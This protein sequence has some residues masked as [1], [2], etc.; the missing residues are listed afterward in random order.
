MPFKVADAPQWKLATQ[1]PILPIE[2][3]AKYDCMG[4][5]PSRAYCS[6]SIPSGFNKT[7]DCL[8][9]AQGRMNLG[10]STDRARVRIKY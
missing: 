2:K 4:S 3:P 7:I 10:K 9:I 8:I 6:F 5:G 1:S